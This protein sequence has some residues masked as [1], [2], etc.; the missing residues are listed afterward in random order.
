LEEF[1]LLGWKEKIKAL[2]NHEHEREPEGDN[3]F[4][5]AQRGAP[6]VISKLQQS[7]LRSVMKDF[8]SRCD[9]VVCE[10]MNRDSKGFSSTFLIHIY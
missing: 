6:F 2:K 10:I 9:N 1:L 5:F 7:R 8:V 4:F 3:T